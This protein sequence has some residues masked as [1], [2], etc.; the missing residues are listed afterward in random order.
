MAGFCPLL[1]IVPQPSPERE[2]D[3]TLSPIP[4]QCWKNPTTPMS[5]RTVVG[6]PRWLTDD[7]NTVVFSSTIPMQAEQPVNPQCDVGAWMTVTHQKHGRRNKQEAPPL[8]SKPNADFRPRLL[9]RGEAA[10]NLPPTQE[11]GSETLPTHSPTIPDMDGPITGSQRTPSSSS[12]MNSKTKS[13]AHDSSTISP[14]HLSQNWRRDIAATVVIRRLGFS[15]SL[16]VDARGFA[17]GIWLLWNPELVSISEIGC[18]PQALHIHVN[19]DTMPPCILTAIY[20]SPQDGTCTFFWKSLWVDA[21]IKLL[22]HATVGVDLVN[23]NKTVVDY[24][25]SDGGWNLGKLR[26]VLPSEVIGH[27]V[28]MSPPRQDLGEYV[29]VCGGK[30]T[31]K[32]SIKSA[33]ELIINVDGR[34]ADD[35]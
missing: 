18:H 22:D 23:I 4:D 2:V 17:R 12:H 27:I 14:V 20:S 11:E 24:V 30:H 9:R 26:Y 32:F 34:E 1:G 28:G 6:G 31:G 25:A 35:I 15:E 10:A 29:W 21:G 33:Y 16:V 3:D 19:A 13:P 7:N 8:K 5:Y